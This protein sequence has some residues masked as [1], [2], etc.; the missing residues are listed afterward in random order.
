M[1]GLLDRCH[2]LALP[3]R[4]E[5]F[6]V[7]ILEALAA[8]RPVVATDVG[9]AREVLGDSS[10]IVVAP[11][12]PVALAAALDQMVDRC[13]E[14]YVPKALASDVISRYGAATIGQ[15]WDRLYRAVCARQR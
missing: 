6:G 4:A 15:R 8:G 7:V 13:T 1:A 12:D 14:S 3:S 2:F 5:T 10:G 9:A 11:G